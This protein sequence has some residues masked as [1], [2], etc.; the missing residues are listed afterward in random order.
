M[1]SIWCLTLEVGLS[2]LYTEFGELKQS[3]VQLQ[4]LVITLS[5]RLVSQ[6]RVL[7]VCQEITDG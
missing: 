4:Q 2:P 5:E 3:I 6:E 1:S 7:L